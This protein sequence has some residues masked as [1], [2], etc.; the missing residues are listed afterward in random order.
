[1]TSYYDQNAERFF[2]DTV[3]VDLSSLQGAFLQHIPKGG[4]ILDAGCGSGRDSKAFLDQGYRVAAFDT[5]AQL[6]ALASVH[7]GQHVVQ[8][9]FS[10]MRER[11]IYDGV[12]ACASLLHVPLADLPSAL[13]CLWVSL[14]PGGVFYLSFKAGQGEFT[15]FGRQF[16]DLDEEGLKALV[17]DLEEV[18]RIQLWRTKDQRPD[19]TEVWLNGLI[20]RRHAKVDKLISGGEENP[21]FARV[22]WRD[23]SSF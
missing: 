16:T 21:F 5:S 11:A 13:R 6:A 22:A 9:G 7:I 3:G 14:K 18:D 20:H 8:R 4:F 10:D 12:W 23:S 15:R 2:N 1:M 17:A 19:R